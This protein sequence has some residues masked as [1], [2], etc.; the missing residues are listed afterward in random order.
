MQESDVIK[1]QWN[2]KSYKI[3]RSDAQHVE[4]AEQECHFNICKDFT[5]TTVLVDCTHQS[6]I[7]KLSKSQLFVLQKILV[8]SN[9]SHKGFILGITGILN[10]K[11]ISIRKRINTTLKTPEQKNKLAKQLQRYRNRKIA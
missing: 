9:N 10:V 3:I 4:A 1:M 8:S 7:T 6:W 5:N 2:C 11:G